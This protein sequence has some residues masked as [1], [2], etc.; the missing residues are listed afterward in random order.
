VVLI[1]GIVD[2]SVFFTSEAQSLGMRMFAVK[3][4]FVT[5]KKEIGKAINQT[6]FFIE[7]SLNCL[8]FTAEAQRKFWIDFLEINP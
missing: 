5:K 1:I 2:M 6:V 7:T 8:F 3:V 4:K